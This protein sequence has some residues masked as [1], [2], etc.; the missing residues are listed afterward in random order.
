MGGLLVPLPH[1]AFCSSPVVGPRAPTC[2]CA[3]WAQH[4][5]HEA[6]PP[7]P[8]HTPAHFLQ[9]S[10]GDAVVSAAPRVP[11]LRRRGPAALPTGVTL[12]FEATNNTLWQASV[13]HQGGNPGPS[14]L[15]ALEVAQY[16]AVPRV[17]NLALTP[18]QQ[19][20]PRH[21]P[22]RL[23]P[24]AWPHLHLRLRQV[25]L[26]GLHGLLFSLFH[27][28]LLLRVACSPL[29]GLADGPLVSMG[30]RSVGFVA[31][32]QCHRAAAGATG[33]P[34][35][36]QVASLW[37][38]R[39]SRFRPLDAVQFPLPPNCET[40]S[41]VA[42]VAVLVDAAGSVTTRTAFGDVACV[43]PPAALQPAPLALAACSADDTACVAVGAFWRRNVVFVGLASGMV[44]VLSWSDTAAVWQAL[45]TAG[46]AGGRAAGPGSQPQPSVHVEWGLLDI[47]EELQLPGGHVRFVVCS[48]T[49]GQGLAGVATVALTNFTLGPR[50][51]RGSADAL[52]VQPVFSH[53]V[54]WASQTGARVVA[55][56][57]VK[58][59]SAVADL[60]RLGDVF[61]SAG[62]SAATPVEGAG[63]TTLADAAPPVAC[64]VGVALSTGRVLGFLIR[65]SH[66]GEGLVAALLQCNVPAFGPTQLAALSFAQS[67]LLALV[68]QD[69]PGGS[70]PRWAPSAPQPWSPPPPPSTSRTP[71]SGS[72]PFRAACTQCRC[73][74]AWSPAGAVSTTIFTPTSGY[75]PLLAL[76][77]STSVP[78]GSVLDGGD[79]AD[80]YLPVFQ[81][82]LALQGTGPGFGPV[83]THGPV[84]CRWRDAGAPPRAA[85]GVPY[86]FPTP[87]PN[88]PGV[89]MGAVAC[90]LPARRSS[91]A[92]L[93]ARLALLRVA[94]VYLLSP[95]C[96]R[97]S[98]VPGGGP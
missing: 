5:T 90:V 40:S 21:H 58:L 7:P 9:V 26:G 22:Y 33:T 70:A 11:R 64:H 92:A 47:V 20:T 30:A 16:V 35:R 71:S 44:Q 98:R 53:N 1:T 48:V 85:T 49:H 80:D 6:A 62:T 93:L 45:G 10:Q 75:V 65:T 24:A 59:P 43:R 28:L 76:S 18:P 83:P 95:F 84:C 15:L 42:P 51:D 38:P 55:A 2:A 87:I 12:V 4:S 82:T 94:G 68:R 34:S 39:L 61:Q 81:G 41:A 77:T 74:C 86:S 27:L 78:S 19:H 97:A 69:G 96:D 89:C 3:R 29:V 88:F 57:A 73:L 52:T 23:S 31:N 37:S 54:E 79:G 14:A 50:G 91:M 25:L 17:F 66:G 63:P 32:V 13:V 8:P 36:P 60:L 56:C 46:V 67:G 72:T